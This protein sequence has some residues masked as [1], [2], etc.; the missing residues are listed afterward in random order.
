MPYQNLLNSAEN[1]EPASVNNWVLALIDFGDRRGRKSSATVVAALILSIGLTGYILG[2]RFSLY[3]FYLV[4][5]VLS[6]LWFGWRWG[7]AV[8]VTCILVRVGID[9]VNGG[10]MTI[11]MFWNR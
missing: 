11:G 9:T 6:A 8:A 7:C 5:I 10:I 3:A 4:P 2:T 1:A